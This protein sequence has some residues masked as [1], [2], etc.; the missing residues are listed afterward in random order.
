[1]SRHQI[2]FC[3]ETQDTCN[4]LKSVKAPQ[5]ALSKDRAAEVCLCP[6]MS[7]MCWAIL[8]SSRTK[9]S[10]LKVHSNVKKM[11]KSGWTFFVSTYELDWCQV[12]TARFAHTETKRSEG[13]SVVQ[14]NY[15]SPHHLVDFHWNSPSFSLICFSFLYN[16]FW[17]R[18]LCVC[19][20]DWKAENEEE[21]AG[22]S[23]DSIDESFPCV[24]IYPCTG[25]MFGHG[26]TTTGLRISS[27]KLNELCENIFF[28]R[29]T[30]CPV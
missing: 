30:C 26:G 19:R 23:L 28:G 15:T 18:M 10:C 2:L 1:M 29:E 20:A 25:Q 24:H 21:A 8:H 27:V 16:L 4:H 6:T 14:R 9:Q 3:S 13:S 11:I 7:N 12:W 22:T 17:F 5:K